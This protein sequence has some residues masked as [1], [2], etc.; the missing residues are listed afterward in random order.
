MF[1]MDGASS[2]VVIHDGVNYLG[3]VRSR[4]TTRGMFALATCLAASLLAACSYPETKAVS[5]WDPKSAAAYLDQRQGWWAQWPGAARD[6]GTYC[7]A[8]HTSV[9]YALSRP[10]LRSA[11]GEQSPSANE[12]GLIDNVTKRVRLWKDVEP[13][14]N[15]QGYK[16][17]ESRATEA[18]VNALILAGYDTQNGRLSSD[19][20][21]AFDNMWALQ[22]TTGGNKGAWPWLQFD[23][24]PWEANDSQYYGATLAAVAVGIAPG[25]YRTAPEVQTN[26]G[27]LQQ[28]LQREYATQ[29]TINRVGLLWASTKLPGLLQPEQQ[30]SIINQVLSKQQ[31][32]GGWKLPSLVWTWESSGLS[33]LVRTWIKEDGTPLE[34]K[35][36]SF[37]TGFITFVLQ[38]AGVPR[39]NA[40]VQR[41]LSWLMRNQETPGGLWR[42]HSLNKRRTPSS[43]TALFMSD[44]ATAFA[45]LALTENDRH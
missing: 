42:S 34:T 43:D 5:S 13:Y 26:L 17:A 29:S 6:H 38:Q 11:L 1:W 4:A 23:L 45:V 25:N 37:A 16:P 9:A 19:T 40:H 21:E 27:L 24:E 44:A 41:G 18:V 8:C 20:K 15:D 10:A 2:V 14:Y 22:E 33:S 36:D 28:Y 30:E 32:D 12:R 3:S 39:D 31:A 7:V 35:S